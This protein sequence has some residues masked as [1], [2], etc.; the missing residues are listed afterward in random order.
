MKLGQRETRQYRQKQGWV[1]LS[2]GKYSHKDF[3][4][5]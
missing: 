5:L 4:N 2:F 3:G 1:F